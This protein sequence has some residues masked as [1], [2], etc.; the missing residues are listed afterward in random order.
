MYL[1]FIY[2]F[3]II[4]LYFDFSLFTRINGFL[5]SRHS[6]VES[7]KPSVDFLQRLDAWE[8]LV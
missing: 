4:D 5:L 2:L 1:L 6:W 3:L 7:M 8:K